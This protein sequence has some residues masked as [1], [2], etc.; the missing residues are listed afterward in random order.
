[1]RLDITA[2]Q[3]TQIF[4]MITNDSQFEPEILDALLNL[5]Q[6]QKRSIF[7]DV[8]SN[9]GIFP[10][11]L[12]KLMQQKDD[13]NSFKQTSQQVPN[14]SIHAHEP[15]PMLQEISRKLMHDNKVKYDLQETAISNVKGEKSLYVSA[16]SD[17]SNSLM[18]GFRPSKE[19]IQVQV[20]TLD[21]LYLNYLSTAQHDQVIIKIDVETHEPEVLEGAQKILEK[22]R[23]IIICE[24]LA[25]RTEERLELIFKSKDYAM[26]RFTGATWIKEAALF[27]DPNYEYRDWIFVPKELLEYFET[28]LQSN[29]KPVIKFKTGKNALHKY[30]Q[31]IKESVK[32]RIRG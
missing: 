32:K 19:V 20:N 16:M 29:L 21:N 1:M 25:K 28:Q 30:Y 7:I 22:I 17:S 23:P 15:L 9:I 27:G 12:A 5:M 13:E 24:V 3:G 4:K 10:L 18:E 11:I 31:R 8:G 6:V 14:I 2:S 26:F